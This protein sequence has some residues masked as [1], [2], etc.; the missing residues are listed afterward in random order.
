[1]SSNNF[2]KGVAVGVA[3]GTAIGLVVAPNSKDMKKAVGKFLKAAGGV[4]ENIS[5]IW[6]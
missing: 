5:N 2:L 1:M 3:A 6:E 4:V